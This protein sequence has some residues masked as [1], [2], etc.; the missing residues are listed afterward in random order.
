MRKGVR[1][2]Q[3]E[4]QQTVAEEARSIAEKDSEERKT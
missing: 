1:Q 4:M 3:Q 2:K